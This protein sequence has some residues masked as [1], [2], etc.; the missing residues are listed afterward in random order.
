MPP[1]VLSCFRGVSPPCRLQPIGRTISE[2]CHFSR[3]LVGHGISRFIIQ[4]HNSLYFI[5]FRGAVEVKSLISA[6]FF[7]KMALKSIHIYC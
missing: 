4:S 6:N 7:F 2:S 3:R 5:M 1:Y